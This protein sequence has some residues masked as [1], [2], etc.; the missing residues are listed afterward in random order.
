VKTIVSSG[1]N[2]RSHSF[3]A[4]SQPDIDS[5]TKLEHTQEKKASKAQKDNSEVGIHSWL[6]SAFGC[7]MEHDF[8]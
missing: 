7:V 2:E 1:L 8:G 5:E 6:E 4:L 3:R